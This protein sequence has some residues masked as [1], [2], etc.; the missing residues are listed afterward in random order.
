MTFFIVP[1]VAKMFLPFEIIFITNLLMEKEINEKVS[2]RETLILRDFESK[3]QK[4]H[5]NELE[6]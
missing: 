2:F 6:A 3:R 4:C 5:A 1:I